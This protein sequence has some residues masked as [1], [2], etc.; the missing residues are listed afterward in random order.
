MLWLLLRCTLSETVPVSC[1]GLLLHYR[2]AAGSM[3]S[4]NPEAG[5][6]CIS[7]MH[8]DTAIC[9]AGAMMHKLI[10]NSFISVKRNCLCTYDTSS[11]CRHHLLTH[12][13]RDI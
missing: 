6:F 5:W 1:H 7:R 8:K 4:A 13:R 10:H 12:R 11:W 2:A 9:L 3:L